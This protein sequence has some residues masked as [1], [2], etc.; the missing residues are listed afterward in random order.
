MSN[1][2]A[3]VS[4]TAPA[5]NGGTP[6]TSYTATSTPGGISA[7]GPASPILVTGL[8]NGVAYTFIVTATN[9]V[10]TGPSSTPSNPVIPASVP[11]TMAAPTVVVASGQAVVSFVPPAT[12]GKPINSYRVTASPGGAFKTGAGSPLTVTGLTNG[13]AYTFT[14][15]A[16]NIVGNGLPSPPS[17]S[18]TPSGVPATMVAPIAVGGNAQATVSFTPPSSGGSPITSYTITASP[19]GLT[20]SGAASPIVVPGLTNGVAYTF[21][22]KATNAIGTGAASPAS[23]SVTPLSVPSTMA[24]P[25]ALAGNAQAKVTFTA[26]FNGGSPITS[27]TVTSSPGAF[28]STGAGSP[29]TV[30]GLSN[31]TAYTFSA[32]ATNAIGTSTAS[33]AS[34]SVTPSGST[35]IIVVGDGTLPAPPVPSAAVGVPYEL[36][37]TVTNSTNLIAWS[38]LAGA[39]AGQTIA[40]FGTSSGVFSWPSPVAGLGSTTIQ[41]T[42]T[43]TGATGTLTI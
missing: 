19:G 26:P 41:A 3:L 31:G 29:L 39:P 22:A 23:N 30:S 13:T 28:Q 32:T 24:A 11:A 38:L 34:N 43:V 4:F 27:Y 16:T 14:V 21:T 17:A 2:S 1:Q 37:V 40:A 36:P 9:A 7:S 15:F 12:G 18:V 8:T 20:Q 35:L 10:G 5:N 42:D 33:P 6:I 25:V